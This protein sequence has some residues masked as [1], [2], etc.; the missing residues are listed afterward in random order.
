LQ[1][2]ERL[3]QHIHF[4]I[5]EEASQDE[6]TVAAY[7]TVELDDYLGGGPIQHREVQGYESKRFLSYFKEGIR[8]GSN[9]LS[10]LGVSL[11]KLFAGFSTVVFHQG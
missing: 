2:N 6:I 5:G 7:K 11:M 8:S 10:F 3:E 9:E 1:A 4:W